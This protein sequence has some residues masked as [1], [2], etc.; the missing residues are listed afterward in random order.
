MRRLQIYF[1]DKL[2][3]SIES[4]SKFQDIDLQ[5][6]YGCLV[7]IVCAADS[8]LHF[9]LEQI[10]YDLNKLESLFSTMLCFSSKSK[11]LKKFLDS[12]HIKI[13][14]KRKKSKGVIV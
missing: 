7:D 5:K 1:K 11:N 2:I 8:N 3:F 12:F 10:N 4:Q 13:V 14:M 9:S 6:F